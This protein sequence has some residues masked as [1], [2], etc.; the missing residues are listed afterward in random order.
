MPEEWQRGRKLQIL[1]VDDHRDTADSLAVLLQLYGHEAHV[2][3]D[4]PSAVQWAQ[5]RPPDA[6][7]L[8]LALPGMDGYETARRLRQLSVGCNPL[9]IAVTGHGR[10]ADRLRSQAE[11][12]DRHF[13]K[14]AD[15]EF[16]DQVLRAFAHRHDAAEV[17]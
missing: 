16:L 17:A 15:P 14:P 1:V 5:V 7:I 3:Y 10:D 11:G 4:G 8:D 9:L 2:A 12:F 6:V 13:I